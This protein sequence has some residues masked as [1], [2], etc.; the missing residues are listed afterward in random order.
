MS[1]TA[2]YRE[3]LHQIALTQITGIGAVNAK[4]LISYCGG[5]EAIFHT[6]KRQ[7]LKIP[8]I[9]PKTATAIL[10]HEEALEKAHREMEFVQKHNIQ[11]IFFFD[12]TYPQRLKNCS[13]A[14]ILLYFKG[15]ADFNNP[16]TVSIVGTRNATD[17]G[18]Q[19]CKELVAALQPYTVLVV[20]GLAYGID[21]AAHQACVK[22]QVATVGVLGHGLDMLYPSQHRNL[23]KKMLQNGGLITDFPS[24]TKPDSK[25][26]P[27]R[28]RIIAGMSDATIV[29]ETGSKGGS[30]ITAYLAQSYNREIFAVPGPIHAPYSMGCNQLIKKNVAKLVESVEDIAYHLG[31][32]DADVAVK[33]PVQKAL[34]VELNDTETILVNLLKEKPKGISIDK[35]CA[36]AKMTQNAVAACLLQLEMKN[37][38]EA[39]PGKRYRLA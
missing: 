16:H 1:Q 19:I 10:Q 37:L 18:R 14:P 34:F 21:H 8:G 15:N 31:W 27:M 38:V 35:I 32:E 33:K 5:V 24:E 29:V 4:S 39:M 20:S 17:Y 11:T 12:E 6:P 7:L 22:N 2:I 36:S 23:A 28:N 30:I 26:F 13:N 25:N 3:K 9:G